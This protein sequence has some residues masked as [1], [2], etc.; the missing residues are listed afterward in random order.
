MQAPT[1]YCRQT[2]KDRDMTFVDVLRKL[3][4]LRFGAVAGTCRNAV[5]RPTEL[6]MDDV[7]NAERDLI[8]RED[9]TRRGRSEDAGAA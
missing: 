1:P 8:R 6:Q 3:G 7:L 4:I 5:E 9:L 2:T